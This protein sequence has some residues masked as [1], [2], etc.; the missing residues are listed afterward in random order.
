MK[1]DFPDFIEPVRVRKMGQNV[2]RYVGYQVKK[3]YESRF[4]FAEPSLFAVFDFSLIKG[5]PSSALT[6]P[7]SIVLTEET[8]QK[9][10]GK[11]GP[12]GKIIETDPYNDGE[13]M[14]F[15]VTGIAKNVPRN[16]HFHFDFLASYSSLKED[17]TAFGGYY[18][19]CT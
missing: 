7:N 17:A 19:H 12:L 13:L 8:A 14:L 18:Q 5:D 1:K 16:S 9:Y 10:F 11:E 3:F 15:H 6:A 4:F 2:K